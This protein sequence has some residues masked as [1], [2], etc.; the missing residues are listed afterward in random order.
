M[1]ARYAAA[2]DLSQVL[3]DELRQSQFLPFIGY[4]IQYAGSQMMLDVQNANP[5][6]GT[7]VW[8]F[9]AN[10]TVAQAFSFEDAGDGLV[11]I[12]SN[13]SNLYLTV[14]V[15]HEPPVM[16]NV[17]AAAPQP[18]PSPAP[19]GHGAGLAVAVRNALAGIAADVRPVAT[20]GD[21]SAGPPTS[22]LPGLIQDVKYAPT[23]IL[24]N[25]LVGT[26]N[27]ECQIW[28]LSSASPAVVDRDLFVIG[29]QAFPGKLLQPADPAQAG[30]AVVLGDPEA[31]PGVRASKNAW[32]VS[33]PLIYNELVMTQ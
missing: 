25:I 4:N 20:T 19:V 2:H 33:S 14:N 21:V 28:R 10:G 26:P 30:S 17:E 24:G 1:G 22:A 12:R 16:A 8:Q 5:A 32:K 18:Q 23:G 15:A 11:Y 31:N 6:P 3:G 29:S 27:P 9:G 7:P 13:V